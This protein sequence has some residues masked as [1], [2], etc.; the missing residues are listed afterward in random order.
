MSQQNYVTIIIIIIMYYYYYLLLFWLVNA[1][2]I[3]WPVYSQKK[4]IYIFW[5]LK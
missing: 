3:N 4:I 2:E 5:V 1:T